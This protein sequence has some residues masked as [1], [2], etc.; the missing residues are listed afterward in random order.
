VLPPKFI[1]VGI[2]TE[3][4]QEDDNFT[5]VTQSGQGV[6]ERTTPTQEPVV[7]N[8]EMIRHGQSAK[9][10]GETPGGGEQHSNNRT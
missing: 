9:I 8:I 2:Q 1:S 6:A 5:G 7:P 10:N 4:I 3:P